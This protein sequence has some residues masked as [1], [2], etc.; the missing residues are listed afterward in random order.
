MRIIKRSGAE[1]PFDI[2]K[3]ILAITKA[4]ETVAETERITAEQIQ[5]IARQ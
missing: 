5:N 2:Q 4:N 1:A 3:I